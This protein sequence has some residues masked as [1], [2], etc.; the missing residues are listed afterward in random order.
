MRSPLFTFATM[1]VRQLVWLSQVVGAGISPQRMLAFA[2][3][4]DGS[5]DAA[6]MD[7]V[8]EVHLV[9]R[10]SGGP[11]ERTLPSGDVLVTL[12][13]SVPR[14]DGTHGEGRPDV[15]ACTAWSPRS[16]RA[17]AGWALGDLVEITGALRH[18]F[19]RTLG[20]TGSRT[21]VEVIRA[22]RVRPGR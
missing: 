14:A 12:R 3:T 7:T 17:V 8:N 2:R 19:F 1:R 15:I 5:G 13:V 6:E 11:E 18:R 16:R 4:L 20:G 22:K 10:L 9:G 21:E